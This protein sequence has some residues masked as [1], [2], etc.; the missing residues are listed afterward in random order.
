MVGVADPGYRGACGKEDRNVREKAKN[1]NGYMFR[2]AVLEH[3][4]DLH[5][6]PGNTGYRASRVNSSQVLFSRE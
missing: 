1:E 5:D 2:R 3:H 6:E 4:H